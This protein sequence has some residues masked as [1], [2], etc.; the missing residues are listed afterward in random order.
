MLELL[1]KDGAY[2]RIRSC[3]VRHGIVMEQWLPESSESAAFSEALVKACDPSFLPAWRAFADRNEP[4]NTILIPG[5]IK[6]EVA[7]QILA[8]VCDIP[9]DEDWMMYLGD[10]HA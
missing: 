5:D 1:S 3:T 4:H 8:T 10:P 6:D 7:R 9:E 2:F